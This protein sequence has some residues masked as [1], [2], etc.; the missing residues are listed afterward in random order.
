MDL[1]QAGQFWDFLSTEIA[2]VFDRMKDT[3]I[4]F[5]DGAHSVWQLAVSGAVVSSVLTLLG[6]ATSRDDSSDDDNN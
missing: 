3:Y 5:P 4:M 6:F 1:I 2:T